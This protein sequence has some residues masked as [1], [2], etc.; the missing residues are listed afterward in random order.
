MGIEHFL[1]DADKLEGFD[2]GKHCILSEEL[3]VRLDRGPWIT[4]R[5]SLA[6]TIAFHALLPPLS[7]D[8]YLAL[9]DITDR[10]ADFLKGRKFSRLVALN[11]ASNDEVLSAV[12]IVGSVYPK[13]ILPKEPDYLLSTREEALS[14]LKNFFAARPI[15]LRQGELGCEREP[16]L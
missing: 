1:V 11:D 6:A 10:L 4:S 8:D 2:F 15:R 13:D 5:Y 7:R 14:S 9:V 12:R 3:L 16:R